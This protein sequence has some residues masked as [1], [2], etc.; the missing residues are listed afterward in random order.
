[1][2]KGKEAIRAYLRGHGYDMDE[3]P[4]KTMR[5]AIELVLSQEKPNQEPVTFSALSKAMITSNTPDTTS[6]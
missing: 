4:V 2:H 1:M 5:D 6:A 3:T